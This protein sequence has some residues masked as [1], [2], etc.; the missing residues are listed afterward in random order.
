MEFIIYLNCCY[1]FGGVFLKNGQFVFVMGRYLS[2]LWIVIDNN[3]KL[4][5]WWY[6]GCCNGLFK[7]MVQVI[8]IKLDIVYG[9]KMLYKY[10]ILYRDLKVVNIFV[11]KYKFIDDYICDVVDFESLVGIYGFGF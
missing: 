8:C 5:K 10:G 11:C 7:D 4:K 3:M 2:D 6:C 1:L 9:M